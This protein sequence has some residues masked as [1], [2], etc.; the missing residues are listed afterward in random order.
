MPTSLVKA[1][2]SGHCVVGIMALAGLI[3]DEDYITDFRDA[4]SGFG[5]REGRE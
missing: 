4:G 5:C 3:A 2:Y 1:R